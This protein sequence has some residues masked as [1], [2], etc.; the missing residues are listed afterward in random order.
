LILDHSELKRTQFLLSPPW[1]TDIFDSIKMKMHHNQNKKKRPMA[2]VIA[3][4]SVYRSLS[5]LSHD[6]FVQL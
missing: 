3:L 6:V 2:A 5:L 4:V 1:E